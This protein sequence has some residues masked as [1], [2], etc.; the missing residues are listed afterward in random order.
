MENIINYERLSKLIFKHLKKGVFTNFFM[1]KEEAENHIK[2]GNFYYV[3][4]EDFLLLIR[5]MNS[6]YIINFYLKDYK[7]C[8]SFWKKIESLNKTVVFE[9]A[10]KLEN[11]ELI[12]EF[13]EIANKHDFAKKIDRVKLSRAI[14]EA[15]VNLDYNDDIVFNIA[16]INEFNHICDLLN[17]SFDKFIG[18]VPTQAYLQN[19]IANKNVMIA[20]KNNNLIGTI[21]F[22]EKNNEITIKHLAIKS[23][24]QGHKIGKMLVAELINKNQNKKMS[25]WTGKENVQAIKVY[26][27]NGF[28]IDNYMSKVLVKAC[29]AC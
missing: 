1:S 27:S 24:Y 26:Q 10:Y 2:V 22:A 25:V 8:D 29:E 23:E 3:D 12:N 7:N 15:K 13:C 18:C 16:N 9:I 11:E 5:D 6:H 28:T 4:D 20:S 21:R 17:T 14:N 19:D